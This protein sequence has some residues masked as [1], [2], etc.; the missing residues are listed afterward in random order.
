MKRSPLLPFKFNWALLISL[1]FIAGCSD[2]TEK[3]AKLSIE[4][5]KYT[6][7][8]GLDVVLHHDNSDPIAAVAILYHVGSSREIPGRTGFAH[9]FEHVLFQESE[10]VPQDEFFKKIQ[11]VGGTLNGG[12]SYDYTVYYEV[13]PK[14]ALEKVL[15]MESDRMGYLINT[16]TQSAFANQQNV[17]LNEK[18]QRVDNQPYGHTTSI[19]SKNLY[20]KDHP[21]NWTVIGEMEDLKN[22]KLDDVKEFYD[23][24]YGPN[25][26][27]L[28]IAGDFKTEDVK[29]LVD[30]YFSEIKKRQ[31]VSKREPMNVTID[32]TVKLYYEDNFAK[33][34]E[35]TMVWPTVNNYSEDFYP[36]SFLSQILSDGKKAPMYKVMVKEKQLTSETNAYNMNLELA[37]TFNVVLKANQGHS[38]KELEEGVF[39]SF[40]RFEKDGI[41]ETDLERIKAGLETDFYQG[42]SSV[43][44][45][46]F[47]LAIFNAM[48]DDP[49]Y[50]EKHI[51][52]IRAVSI[53]DIKRVYNKYIKD[54][55]YV[56]TSFVPKGQTD[57][58]AGGAVK[59]NVQEE[60]IAGATEV[61]ENS[62]TEKQEI[63]KTPSKID[64]DVEPELGPE[65]T[66]T[67]P[68]IWT[69]KMDNG[70]KLYGIEQWEIPLVQF[71][72]VLDGGLSADDIHKVG[73]ANLITDVMMEGTA[74]KTPEELEEEIKLL[75]ADIH[76][77][78]GRESI[79]IY[80]STLARNFNKTLAL[81][82]EMILEP[83]WDEEQFKLKK[84]KT[85]NEIKQ[86]EANPDF[87]AYSEFNNLIYGDSSILGYDTY[88]KSEVVETITIDDL[89][90]YYHTYFAPNVASFHVAGAISKED[91]EKALADLSQNWGSKEV[92]FANYEQPSPPEK[93]QLYFYDVP[94]AKQSVIRIGLPSIPRTDP[95]YYA[96]ITMN[97]KLGGSFS[98]IL[99]MIL[100]EEKGYTYGARSYFSGM[101]STGAFVASASVRSNVTRES[102]EIFRDEMEKYRNGISEEDL[103][104]TKNALIRSNARRFETLN[105]L[106]DMLENISAY[107]LPVDYVKQEES[108]IREM[109]Q[110]THK[111]LVDK[112]IKPSKMIYLVVGDANT[113]LQGLKKLGLG[114][115]V[116]LN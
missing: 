89:K 31:D 102:V 109:D 56:S 91:V 96:A 13:V 84:T 57:L 16:L 18:R 45:K 93:A 25:N 27:T 106:V 80:G 63:V 44:Y 114:N 67:I 72:L 105:A 36:L 6:L 65:P 4:Y 32:S 66:L 107:N 34:P 79:S 24:Y 71:S 73:V 43:L 86:H 100:R 50:G 46:S 97:Y 12:T 75:G 85:I 98:G 90:N 76:M 39:E 42:M 20:P 19:I 108:I 48:K 113:Q 69:D 30:K 81:V 1:L 28:I 68:E 94:G 35:L 49:A 3:D 2:K 14:N 21:Y 112:Y 115:P 40:K 10:H 8:N 55:P 104:F 17:V 101:K 77:A 15:W 62:G 52:K 26:A 110:D 116:L 103:Q 9:L 37:G 41:T 82:K 47:N 29:A 61:A 78:T 95:D 99:N 87:I 33:V 60:S 38:L 58:I 23:K 83:R 22:A 111:A 5:E 88:G 51:E 54:K 59:A 74:N 11:N 64:R 7:E 70:L 92:T 53:D